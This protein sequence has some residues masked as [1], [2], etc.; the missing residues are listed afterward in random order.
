VN[1][2]SG[3]VGFAVIAAAVEVVTI[4][5]LLLGMRNAKMAWRR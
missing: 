2:F 4:K 5:L 1:I 3:F